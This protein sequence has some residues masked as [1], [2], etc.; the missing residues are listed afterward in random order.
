MNLDS[1]AVEI[2]A[3]AM[4]ENVY[5]SCEAPSPESYEE[6]WHSVRDHYRG[7]AEVAIR[8]YL[9]AEPAIPAL[10][11]ERDAAVTGLLGLLRDEYC[12]AFEAAYAV[13]DHAMLAALS[14]AH[15]GDKRE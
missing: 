2:A 9:A 3:R 8:A 10:V 14:P 13:R 5:S 4:C 11:A 1:G 6:H 12:A 15:C 7:Q